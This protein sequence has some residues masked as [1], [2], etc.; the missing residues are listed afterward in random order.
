MNSPH[1]T[2]VIALKLCP[3]HT[4]NNNFIQYYISTMYI[5]GDVDSAFTSRDVDPASV[6]DKSEEKLTEGEMEDSHCQT[7]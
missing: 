7:D 1:I 2:A 5:A 3:L 6:V 4:Y